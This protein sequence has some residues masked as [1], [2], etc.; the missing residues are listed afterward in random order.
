MHAASAE[1]GLRRRRI[2]AR[3]APYALALP[4]CALAAVF[5]YGV[6]VGVLQGFGIMPSLGMN[7]FTLDYYAQALARPDFTA[8]IAYSLYLSA[9]SSAIALAGGV[10]LAWA[11]CAVQA[12]T[13][14]R[15]LGLQV[16]ILT[17]HALVALAV[18]FLF[19]GSG[20]VARL[21]AD[22][23]AQSA[24]QSA[25]S[26]VGDPS[27]WGIVAVYAWK[28]IPYVAFCT[29]TI[30]M[31]VSGT[32]G[33]AAAL[34]GASPA[35][36]FFSVTLPLCAPAAVQAFVVVA[37]FSF[38]S[39]EVAYLLGPTYPKTLPVLA[40]MEFQDPDLVNRCYAMAL[41]GITTGV[42]ALTAAVYFVAARVQRRQEGSRG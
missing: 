31:H 34:S 25:V 4:A 3:L 1:D 23:A 9:V 37:A 27:G 5:A 42:C 18:T 16:P 2:A 17:M 36:T 40:Y 24:A 21:L 19:S 14:V 6:I 7:S 13:A 30:M 12:R 39:Y 29:I 38:G 32:L 35:R 28:E 15:M 8:S 33:E 20:L 10:L 41:N 26:V 11:L 22:P